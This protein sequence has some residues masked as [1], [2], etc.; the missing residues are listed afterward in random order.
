M[1][2]KNPFC[3]NSGFIFNGERGPNH[4]DQR[5]RHHGHIEPTVGGN[6]YVQKPRDHRAGDGW[7][8]GNGHFRVDQRV[9]GHLRRV[10]AHERPGEGRPSGTIQ[11]PRG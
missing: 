1:E 9:H 8:V 7:R 6:L 10:A 2:K 4:Y 3:R 5:L 11:E